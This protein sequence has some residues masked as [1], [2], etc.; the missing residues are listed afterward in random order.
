MLLIK[1]SDNASGDSWKNIFVV[2]NGNF[3]SREIPIPEGEWE[4]V[5]EDYQI[6]ENGLRSI[7]GGNY[8]M[9]ATSALILVQK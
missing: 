9:G 7:S 4:V 6:D 5:L 1:I 2:F 3:E 8:K